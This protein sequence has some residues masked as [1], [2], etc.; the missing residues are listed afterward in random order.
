MLSSGV[1]KWFINRKLKNYDWLKKRTAAELQET[2]GKLLPPP[3]FVTKPMLHQLVCFIIAIYRKNFL[4]LLDLGTGKTKIILDALYYWLFSGEI[5]HALVL[6]PNRINITGWMDEVHKHQPSLKIILLPNNAELRE[7]RLAAPFDIAVCTYAGFQT[8][9][10]TVKK[11]KREIDPEKLGEIARHFQCVVYDE[12]HSL[13]NHRSINYKVAYLLQPLM[14]FRYGLTGTPFGRNVADL[15]AQFRVIDDGK[16]LGRTL[17]LFRQAFFE[18][19]VNYFGGWEYKLREDRTEL[20]WETIKNRS[21]LY[22]ADD[23]GDL[24]PCIRRRLRLPFPEE[25]RMYYDRILKIL[26]KN[27][28]DRRVVEN[29]FLRLRQI[30]SGFL[31]LLPEH[32]DG[33]RKTIEFMDNP[34]LEALMGMFDDVGDH[35]KIV[36]FHE[37]TWSGNRIAQ[38]LKAKKIKFAKLDGNTK[39]PEKEYRK[40]KSDPKCRGFI[41]NSKAGG[42]GTN[43]QEARYLVYYESPTSPIIRRQTEKRVHRTGQTKKTFI[44][45]LVVRNTADARILSFIK[46]GNDLREAVLLGKFQLADLFKQ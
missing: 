13:K 39:D 24:P 33:L 45:D 9:C 8:M 16:T 35:N 37:F 1:V 38:E 21:I 43:L 4:F 20:L 28:K 23:C 14:K 18:S 17:T 29:M 30:S 2:I 19:K 3:R 36:V 31:T 44:I 34:K 11:H 5:T 12:C 46:E 7:A 42:T 10:G 26:K 25:T 15:W 41:I 22:D 27:R 40:F 32:D 6:V